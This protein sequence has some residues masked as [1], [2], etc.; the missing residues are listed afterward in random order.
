MA[1]MVGIVGEASYPVAVRR[2]RVGMAAAISREPDNPHDRNAL[3]VDIGGDT[4]GYIARGDW[5]HEAL[6]SGRKSVVAVVHAV[7]KKQENTGIVLSVEL[8]TG[9]GVGTVSYVAAKRK[10]ANGKAKGAR[11]TQPVKAN[12]RLISSL[13][14]GLF[15]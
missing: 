14:K 11:Q 13:I 5:L 1:Y 7:A 12:G 9:S 3:R 15:R 10:T 6:A 8:V 4:V 2:V